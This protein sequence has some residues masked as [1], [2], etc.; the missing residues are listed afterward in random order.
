M[1]VSDSMIM[2]VVALALNY[3]LVYKKN[4]FFGNVLFL[5]LGGT[6]WYIDPQQPWGIIMVCIA[7]VN[8]V[9]DLLNK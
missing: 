1:A 2:L 9:Y 8:L 7:L 6:S 3:L 4:R 5:V